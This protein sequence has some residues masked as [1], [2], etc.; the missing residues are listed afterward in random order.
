MKIGSFNVK[1]NIDWLFNR[2]KR[3]LFFNAK[4]CLNIKLSVEL[5]KVFF[6]RTLNWVHFYLFARL[7]CGKRHFSRFTLTVGDL[8]YK[9]SEVKMKE[10]LVEKW[11]TEGILYRKLKRTFRF[12]N[13]FYSWECCRINQS[14][15]LFNNESKELLSEYL[16]WGII[17]IIRFD[18]RTC[19]GYYIQNVSAVVPSDPL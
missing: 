7:L 8:R 5:N 4:I 3:I 2:I 16:R 15:H 14:K 6:L 10:P 18:I 19:I 13:G 17:I 11:I 12:S 9:P 1:L